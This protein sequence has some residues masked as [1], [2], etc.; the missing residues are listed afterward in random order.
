MREA[1][2]TSRVSQIGLVLVGLCV[3]SCGAASP[4]FAPA[5]APAP[6][7][8]AAASP[9]FDYDVVP[10]GRGVYGFVMRPGPVA[11]VSSNVLLVVG[12]D[13]ALVMDTGLFPSLA[14]KIIRDIRAI[15]PLPVRYV[16]TSHWHLDHL[17]G[18]ATFR[19]AYPAAAFIGHA[20]TR[21]LALK[22]DPQALAIQRDSRA[23]IERY[24]RAL[25]SG[26]VKDEPTRIMLEATLPEL[27]AT[28]G[29]S[30]ISLDP[31]TLTFTGD[32]LTIY[33]GAREVRL[34]HLGRGNTAGDVLT[35]VPDANV[36]ATGDV[37]VAPSPFGYGSYPGEWQ[38]VLGKVIALHPAALLPGHGPVQHDL[39]YA[40]RVADLL[41]AV[42]ARV[43]ALAKQ[44]LSLDVTRA[45]VD[46]SDLR[47]SFVGEDPVQRAEFDLYFAQPI[48]D[49][50]YEE[51]RGAISDE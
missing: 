45:K 1:S 7:P 48:V 2:M 5:P 40:Q 10:L 33:L 44:G 34:L 37:L 18:N 35:Y 19:R 30:D 16:V 28:V 32:S 12:D 42:R 36:L 6:K 50:S 31:P 29:E 26:K 17:V 8:V 47:A 49:R 21:R 38:A 41:R 51:S 43:D 23:T 11:T 15:T 14:E 3:A 22:N 25:A 39:D 46:L 20:E 24:K 9:L 4:A 27:Q 13:C